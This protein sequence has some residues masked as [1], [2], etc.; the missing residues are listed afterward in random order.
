MCGKLLFC[1]LLFIGNC[2]AEA[3]A[4]NQQIGIF[5]QPPENFDHT[6]QV[7]ACVVQVGNRIL[8]LQRGS[9]KN[10]PAKWEVPGGK[11]HKGETLQLCASRELFEET[12]IEQKIFREIGVLYVRRVEGDFTLRVVFTEQQIPPPVKISKEHSAYRWVT[13]DE[14]RNLDLIK[15]EELL[16]DLY[17]G[18]L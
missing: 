9:H 3:H 2:V 11:F 12:G 4:Q 16:I 1:L 18:S 7:S 14:M 13:A 15:G 17:L 8:A 6:I 5:E 10:D